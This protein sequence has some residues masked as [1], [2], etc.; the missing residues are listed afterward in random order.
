MNKRT[1]SA[2]CLAGLLASSGLA[3]QEPTADAAAAPTP[4]T[5]IATINGQ[6]F[7][8]GMFRLFYAERMRQSRTENSP[9][10][11]NQAF[12]EFVNIVVTAQN[13]ESKGIDKDFNVENALRMHRLQLLSRL[14]LQE[15]SNTLT[16]SDETLK[17][18][19]DERFGQEKRTE[20]KA[21]HILVKT[22]DEAKKLV[23]ELN[24]GGDFVELAKVRSLG[25]TGKTG[26][27]LGWF[28]STQMVKPFTEAVRTMKPGA[29][30]EAPVQTQF[31][32]HVILLEETREA[33]PPTLESVKNELTA[34]LQRQALA[35]FVSE[36]REK[37]DLELNSDLIKATP[38]AAA[39]E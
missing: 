7:S 4:E 29:H 24:D 12:N 27:D 21:R 9:A 32:W 34:G 17:E 38:P 3:A 8:L 37:A 6:D 5:N 1:L 15:V 26:G 14:A 2:C 19:Y 28:D 13:A 25:P 33:E 31:G 20:Y 22:E 18:A 30:S 11:Q 23:T 35:D 39:T 16:P 10:F 36:L